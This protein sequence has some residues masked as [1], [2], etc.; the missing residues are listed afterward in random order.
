M[1]ASL[2]DSEVERVSELIGDIYDCA[3]DPGLWPETLARIHDLIVCANAVLYV[4][5][6]E[7]LSYRMHSIV[8]V[9]AQWERRMYDF[10]A[11]IAAIYNYLGNLP[12]RP[13]DD[14]FVLRRDIADDFLFSNRYFLEWAQPQ[15][16]SDLI[17][18]TLMREPKRLGLFAMGR[19]ERDGRIAGRELR[20]MDLLAP[21]MRRAV[22]ISDIIDMKTIEAATFGATLD[23]IA[24]PVFIVAEDRTV[25]HA[26]PAADLLLAQSSV[27]GVTD[28]RLHAANPATTEKLLA[29]I[30]RK[31]PDDR[32]A[33]SAGVVVSRGGEALTIAHVLP[34]QAGSARRRLLP[35]AAAAVLVTST[36]LPYDPGLSAVAEAFGLTPAETRVLAHI[37]KGANIAET[38]SSLGT[39]EATT[40]THLARI[41]SKTGAKRQTDLLALVNRL[42]SIPLG[43]DPRI[44]ES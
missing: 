10:D 33:D 26:N 30:D 35:D 39:V 9:S 8:G 28:G 44:P 11:D 32:Q 12:T 36:A 25:L 15:G 20:L 1:N 5:D 17:Q 16:I 27:L 43:S 4:Y 2:S 38:S 29:G 7:K 3:I 37:A 21:H 22:K 18:A 34:L 13:L 19:Y 23:G 40:K 24:T 14:Y 31:Q 6:T 41:L 42:T